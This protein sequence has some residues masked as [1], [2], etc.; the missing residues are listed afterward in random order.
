MTQI[1]DTNNCESFNKIEYKSVTNKQT[2]KEYNVYVTLYDYLSV[3]NFNYTI[4]PSL[5]HNLQPKYIYVENAQTGKLEFGSRYNTSGQVTNYYEY[6][7]NYNTYGNDKAK[8][9]FYV[10]TGTN[11]LLWADGLDT[12]FHKIAEYQYD[13][14]TYY[15]ESH[16]SKL[17][18]KQEF[19]PHYT[20]GTFYNEGSTSV[21]DYNLGKTVWIGDSDYKMKDDIY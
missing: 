16:G 8:N 15:R 4:E 5:V 20:N 14:N 12:N 19:F 21:Y 6:Y 13:H 10:K 9:K 17:R 11:E 7:D 2:G 18:Y 3:D 1:L